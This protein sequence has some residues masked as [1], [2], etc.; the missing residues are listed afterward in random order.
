MLEKSANEMKQTVEQLEK[1]ID[2]I[3][4]EGK[5]LYKLTREIFLKRM[6]P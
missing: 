5:H 2:S 4:S 3:D 6:H 1:R